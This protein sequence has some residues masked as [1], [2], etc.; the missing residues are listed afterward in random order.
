M[1]KVLEGK[2]THECINPESSWC[3][4]TEMWTYKIDDKRIYTDEGY[5][6]DLFESFVGKYVRMTI[7]EIDPE[8]PPPVLPCDTCDIITGEEAERLY[9]ALMNPKPDPE[10]TKFIEEALREFPN[11]GEPSVVNIELDDDAKEFLDSL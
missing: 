5:T 6:N 11:P 3:P 1:R 10:R 2:L 7:E 9:D 8:N 4:S